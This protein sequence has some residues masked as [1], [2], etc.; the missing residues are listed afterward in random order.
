MGTRPLSTGEM[1]EEHFKVGRIESKS[2]Q[3]LLDPNLVDISATLFESMLKGAIAV[4]RLLPFRGIRHFSFELFQ[5]TLHADEIRKWFE[6]NV[7]KRSEEHTS[8]LQS[9]VHLV[10]RLLL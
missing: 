1:I 6:T 9:P 4:Q 7:P 2:S 3:H 10:C 8:E 5:F